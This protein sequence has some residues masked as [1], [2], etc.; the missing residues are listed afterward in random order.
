MLG[1]ALAMRSAGALAYLEAELDG[2]EAELRALPDWAPARVLLSE[3]AWLRDKIQALAESWD[4]KLVVA[5]VGPSGAG[6]STLLNALA[7]RELSRTG[8]QR[9]TTREVIV[10]VGNRSDA[11]HLIASLGE[12]AV[13]VHVAAEA[14]PLEHL[15]LVDTPDTNTLPEN[16]RLLARL[17]PLSDLVL[18]VFPAQNPKMQDN[19]AFLAPYIRHLPPGSVVPV[20]NMVDRVPRD[21]LDEIVADCRLALARNWGRTPQRVYLLS[22]REGLVRS[23]VSDEQALHALN[24]LPELAEFVFSSLNRA[25]EVVDR[26]LAN[27][28]HLVALLRGHCAELLG[29]A[30]A[31]RDQARE[32][33]ASLRTSLRVRLREALS[34]EAIRGGSYSAHATVYG[35][36]SG[37]WWGPV[38]WLVAVWAFLLRVGSLFARIGRSEQTPLGSDGVPG[39]GDTARLTGLEQLYAE[40][41]PAVADLLVR[42]G[43]Q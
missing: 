27:A 6:K 29:G 8:L 25:G 17:L 28:E 38:G 12:G 18:A 24:E 4:R 39:S 40:E 35:L 11:D 16:Q 36:L 13:E 32:A 21:Q 20:L 5:I 31:E 3:A 19:L 22:A 10:Y 23:E 2:F 37:R 7:G 33:L 41:W 15:L 14:R 42:A 43:F 1:D 30:V 26:R 34:G 9:P